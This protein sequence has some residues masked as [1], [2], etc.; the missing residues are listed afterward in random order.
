MRAHD[1]SSMTASWMTARRLRAQGI[2]LALC[3]WSV[4]VW[5]LATPG[6]LDRAGNLKGTDFLH[7]YTLGSLAFAHR[8][9]DLYNMR[10]QAELATQRIPGRC[11]HPI[12]SALSTTSV[13]FFAPFARLSYSC[14]A[15]SLVGSERA[16]L[17]IVLL[18]RVARLPRSAPSW[19][20]CFNSRACIPGVLAPHRLGT[21]FRF[22]ASFFR[23]R[24]LRSESSTGVPRWPRVWM[25]HL[26]TATRSRCGH[27]FPDHTPVE[28]YPRRASCRRRRIECC[29][30]LLRS[31]PASRLVAFTA[32]RSPPA[33]AARAETLPNPLPAHVLD[34]ADPVA[35]SFFRALCHQ[36]PAGRRSNH[37]LLAQPTAVILA[38][39]CPAAFDRSSRACISPFTTWSSSRQRCF[40]FP[41]GFSLQ[42]VVLIRC[43]NFSSILLLFFRY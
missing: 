5:N 32:Q 18:C 10:A 26:Q 36:R 28:N 25:P 39:F 27:H 7:F 40:C 16:H 43:L 14:G 35:L 38:L 23:V 3:L 29:V 22:G 13:N 42:P 20:H 34:Y 12:S 4:Y 17:R 31:W 15:G 9:A 37:R 1:I 19:T 21:N 30:A 2:I 6:L 11:G 8:G 33:S 41:I 24:V